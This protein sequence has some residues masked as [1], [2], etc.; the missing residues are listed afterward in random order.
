MRAKVAIGKLAWP[1]CTH[2]FKEMWWSHP[3]HQDAYVEVIEDMILPLLHSID[4]AE[5]MLALK[6]P[7]SVLWDRGLQEEMNRYC[8]NAAL[9]RFDL[10]DQA[11]R[12]LKALGYRETYFWSEKTYREAMEELWPLTR[13]ED[14]AGVAALLHDWELQFVEL[15][16]LQDIYEKKPFPF[17]LTSP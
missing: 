13:A 8:I 2:V 17:Q 12:E 16:G 9:G 5:R 14:K 1:R 4:T 15:H 6:H 10:V 11:A 7:R 3:R